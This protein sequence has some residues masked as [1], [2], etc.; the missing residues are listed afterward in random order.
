MC[1]GGVGDFTIWWNGKRIAGRVCGSVVSG[2]FC[3]EGAARC[4]TPAACVSLVLLAASFKGDKI[5][6]LHVSAN[7]SRRSIN[8]IYSVWNTLSFVQVVEFQPEGK[9]PAERV[10]F[11]DS[12]R[13]PPGRAI[14]GPI[15]GRFWP[16]IKSRWNNYRP[17]PTS[18]KRI[19]KFSLLVQA[20]VARCSRDCRRTPASLR[21]WKSIRS[22]TALFPSA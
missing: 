4:A 6:P 17:S 10:M 1:S 15:F 7:K 8:A 18:G 16:S 5:L 13:R 9:D 20:P 3:L 22:S 12:G 14:S 19:R 21:R 2:V 11:I